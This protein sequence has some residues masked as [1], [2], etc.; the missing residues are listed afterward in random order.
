MTE[1]VRKEIHALTA[2]TAGQLRQKYIEVYGE[3]PRTHNKQFLF[4]RIAWRLQVIEEG[5]SLSERARQRAME[6]ANLA[7]LRIRPPKD[8]A[9]AAVNESAPRSLPA[10]AQDTRLPLPGTV[11]TREYQ[12]KLIC[13]T[14]LEDG[15][16]YEGERYKSLT[17]VARAVTGTHWNGLLFFGV[18]KKRK[19]LAHA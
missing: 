16:E 4:R 7:D 6:I 17:A 12:G 18:A 14:V 11:L 1:N 10:P 13:V 15:F 9:P 5:A 2:M 8:F 3:P 19:E